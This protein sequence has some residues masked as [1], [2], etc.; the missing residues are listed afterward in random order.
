MFYLD[1]VGAS[2][3]VKS[4]VAEGILP[5]RVSPVLKKEPDNLSIALETSKRN[6]FNSNFIAVAIVL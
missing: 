6:S 3:Q 4:R 5:V 1:V 2:G